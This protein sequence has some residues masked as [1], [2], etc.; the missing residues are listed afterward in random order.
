[1]GGQCPNGRGGKMKDQSLL[2]KVCKMFYYQQ[3]SKIEIGEKLRISRYKVARLL[4]EAQNTGLVQ[5]KIV[6]PRK[7]MFAL[8]QQ[9]EQE[10]GLKAVLIIEG[11]DND[12]TLNKKQLASEAANFFI[13]S[14]RDDDILGI[15]WGTTVLEV[16]KA[17]PDKIG[18]NVAQIVQM[19]GGLALLNRV[20][21]I[22]TLNLL[23]SKL[24]A[25]VSTFVVPV[26]VQSPEAKKLS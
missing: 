9:L 17:L 23:G 21:D 12:L 3:L 22:G 18:V 2:L 4:N 11:T 10:L 8:E 15:S 24:N 14:I 1:M 6:N 16:I 7:D 26:L 13:E 19:A 20:E 25:Q 5:I